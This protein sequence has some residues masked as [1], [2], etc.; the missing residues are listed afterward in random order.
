M[1][2]EMLSD[3]R[4]E[5]GRI[6]A[7]VFDF[8]GTVSTLRYGW[9]QVMRPMMIEIL[10]GGTQGPGLEK[11]V[12]DYIDSSTGIQT[13]YQMRWIMERAEEYGVNAGRDE[14]WYKEEYNRR[15]M[16]MISG[17][18]AAVE[19]GT[20]S[21]EEYLILGARPFLQALRDK[22][23]DV[24]VASGT[25]HKDVVHEAEI[26][27]LD[28]LF[29]EIKGAPERQAACSKEAVMRRIIDGRGISGDELVLVGDGKVE[30]ALGVENGA[31]ALG[32]A[33]DEKQRCGVNEQKRRRLTAA[34]AHA[35]TGDFSCGAELLELLGVV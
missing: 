31:F 19:Q 2:I 33:S 22:G 12:D 7:A 30:I 15:L 24:Y 5:K 35:I 10:G 9:E 32:I 28:G 1:S 17:R 27:G 4:P 18:I 34:G 29:N 20:Q 23:V 6:K 8:D 14:W 3:K 26:L 25:D 11:M 16:R 21:A 13:V